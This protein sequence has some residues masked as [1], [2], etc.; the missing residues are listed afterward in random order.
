MRLDAYI[1]KRLRGVLAVCVAGALGLAAVGV[2]RAIETVE[3]TIEEVQGAGWSAQ[4]IAL[5]LALPADGVSAQG[6]IAKVRMANAQ[7][8]W[9]DVRIACPAVNIQGSKIA[10]ANA[11]IAFNMP[12]LG[13]QQLSGFLAYDRASGDIDFDMR[14]P[15]LAGGSVRA[16]G[17]LRAASWQVHVKLNEVSIEQALGMA[18]SFGVAAPGVAGTGKVTGTIDAAGGDTVERAHVVASVSALTANNE[19]GS[20]ASDS[21]ALELDANLVR[22]SDGWQYAAQVEALN[23]Q[24]YAEPVF[25]DF[26]VHPLKLRAA[27]RYA[28]SGAITAERFAIDHQNVMRAEGSVRVDLAQKQPLRDLALD[29]HELA[30]PGAY[31]TYFQPLLLDTDFKALATSGRIEGVIVV[32]DGVPERA[33]VKITDLSIDDGAG[34]LALQ[35]VNGQITWRDGTNEDDDVV[36]R[37][38]AERSSLRWAGGSL[39]NLALGRAAL[40]FTT[41][42]RNFR[43]V[44]PTSIPLLDGAIELESLRVRNLGLPTVAFIVDATIRPISVAQLCRAFGWPE[45]G[46]SLSGSISKLRLRDGV[47]T[48]GTTLEAQVFDGRVAVKDLRLE[49]TLGKWPRF[50]S[51]IELANLDLELVTRAFSF[52]RITG[53]LSGEIND[54]ELFN[55]QPIAFDARLYTPPNDRSRHRI[56]QRAV[57]NIGSIGGGGAGI[58]QALSSGVMKFFDDFGYDKLGL[59][60]RLENEVCHMDGVAPATNGA[61]YLVKGSGLPRIDVIGSNRRVDWP[62]LVSQLIAVTEAEGPVVE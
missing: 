39:L 48:L 2:V 24:A 10:C 31:T 42:G 4:D 9:R 28:D 23:G 20:L 60:C 55:W 40:T 5:E 58:T 27:G 29:L 8:E 11:S 26:G 43:L 3:F 34:M 6:R 35:D 47:V 59:S 15:R 41:I 19:S 13:D 54:L 56:S 16:R 52:G 49:D 21:L 18:A 57:Q 46:G 37:A 45:F 17:A 33:A 12:A 50:H 38:G 44:E 61:Y 14:A 1:D 62:R 22:L 30:F 25:V 53:R 7:R 51:S 36:L 32:N